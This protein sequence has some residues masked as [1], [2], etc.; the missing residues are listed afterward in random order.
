MIELP[1]HGKR[2]MRMQLLRMT[3]IG[4]SAFACPPQAPPPRSLG[5]YRAHPA[6]RSAASPN[7]VIT[8]A[9]RAVVPGCG[10]ERLF[11]EYTGDGTATA[12]FPQPCLRCA[13]EL[14]PRTIVTVILVASMPQGGGRE[15][16]GT[17][18]YG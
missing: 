8:Q 18:D 7:S 17:H 11:R 4:G 10:A 15:I 14:N 12:R 1:V 16:S 5:A 2:Q 9:S 13:D 6:S 3:G